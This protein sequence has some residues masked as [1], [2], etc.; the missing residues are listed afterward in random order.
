MP[1]KKKEKVCFCEVIFFFFAKNYV[2]YRMRKI[3]VLFFMKKLKEIGMYE[4]KFVT[5]NMSL[6]LCHECLE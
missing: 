3:M 5:K 6:N 1:L 4:F 2:F